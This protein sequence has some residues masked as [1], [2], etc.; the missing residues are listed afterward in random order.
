MLIAARRSIVVAVFGCGLMVVTVI[1]HG[2]V[3]MSNFRGPHMIV[4]I[5]GYMRVATEPEFR[6]H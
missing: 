6:R 4:S 1:R 5:V 3:V 2:L